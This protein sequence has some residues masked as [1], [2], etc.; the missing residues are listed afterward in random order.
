MA[1]SLNGGVYLCLVGVFSA[2]LDVYNLGRTG[3]VELI[4]EGLEAAGDLI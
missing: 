1:G 2:L 4:E 3:N